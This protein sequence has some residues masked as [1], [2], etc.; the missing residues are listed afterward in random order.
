MLAEVCR[1]GVWGVPRQGLTCERFDRMAT[2]GSSSKAKDCCGNGGV[3]IAGKLPHSGV[4]R[5]QQ[6]RHGA[7]LVRPRPPS[8]PLSRR[9]RLRGVGGPRRNRTRAHSR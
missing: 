4:R 2:V 7:S 3:A 6:P 9:R 1:R 8:E 5:A